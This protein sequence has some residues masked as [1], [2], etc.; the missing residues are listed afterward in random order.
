MSEDEDSD[1]QHFDTITEI[2]EVAQQP[3]QP[4]TSQHYTGKGKGV[5]KRTLQP[6][7]TSGSPVMLSHSD[8]D[9]VM[10]ATH[11]LLLI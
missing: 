8:S 1:F 7:A 4:S 5:G 10:K 2:Q 9:Q 6:A 11:H 3:E